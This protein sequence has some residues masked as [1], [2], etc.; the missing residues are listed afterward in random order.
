[1][2]SDITDKWRGNETSSRYAT[3]LR[4]GDWYVRHHAWVR[5]RAVDGVLVSWISERPDRIELRDWV[6]AE[7]VRVGGEFYRKCADA[8]SDE[9]GSLSEK[10]E[11]LLRKARAKALARINR[12][13]WIELSARVQP[14]AF[15]R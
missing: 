9:S 8:L 14:E 3:R 11:S 7:S 15:D 5:G 4:G 6:R 1:M 10:Q 12:D 2:M 13:R